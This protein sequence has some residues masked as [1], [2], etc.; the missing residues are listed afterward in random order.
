MDYIN[1]PRF[2]AGTPQHDAYVDELRT[3]LAKFAVGQDPYPYT[4]GEELIVRRR[5]ARPGDAIADAV[6]GSIHAETMLRM[7]PM[8]P[9]TMRF[10][11]NHPPIDP[12][13]R[14]ALLDP[15]PLS[16]ATVARLIADLTKHKTAMVAV[17]GMNMP[18]STPTD[19]AMVENVVEVVDTRCPGGQ[20]CRCPA[21]TPC[22]TTSGL[23]GEG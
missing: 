10:G 22:P 12:E 23:G 20:W 8:L 16:P 18:H 21:S 6:E 14:E 11:T 5:P 9:E 7:L 15:A 19:P 2:P 3:D 1:Q 13:V 4:L 17:H